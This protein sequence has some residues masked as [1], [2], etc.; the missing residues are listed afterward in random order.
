MDLKKTAE[1]NLILKV[2]VGSHLFGTNTP[3][4]DLDYEGIFMPS[5]Q[6]LF[7]IVACREVDLGKICKNEAGRNTNEAIDYKVREYR[8][9]IRLALQNNPN[10]VNIIFANDESVIFENYFGKRLREMANRF[11]HKRGLKR[12]MGY[13]I[14]Q[15][16]KMKIKPENYHAF[17]DAEVFL[18]KNNPR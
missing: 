13:A 2:R 15:M 1:D 14:S 3:D 18:A 6:L 12:F 11:P 7:G 17:Q 8:D 4:S 16:K 5:K 10:I 9:F